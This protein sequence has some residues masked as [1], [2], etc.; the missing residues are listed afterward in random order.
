MAHEPFLI[1]GANG[2]T[3]RLIAERAKACGFRPI[4]A[5]RSRGPVEDI[6]SRVGFEARV[7]ELDSPDAVLE[8]IRGARLVLHCAGPFSKTSRPMVDGCLRAGAHYLDITGEVSVLEAVLSRDAEARAAKVVLLPAVGFDVVPTDCM[9]KTLHEELPDATRLELGFS[10]GMQPSPGTAKSTVEGLQMGAKVRENGAIVT[11]SRPRTRD[12]PFESGA[13]FGMSIP[14]GDLVTA[15]RSTKIPNITVYT[16]VPRNVARAAP[17]LKYV[18]PILRMPSV[19]R[20]LQRT[21]EKRA[22]GPTDEQRKTGRMW[23]WGRVENASGAAVE[24]HLDVSEGYEFTVVAA[25]ASVERVLGGE[26]PPGATT[27][28]LAFGADFVTTLPGASEFRLVHS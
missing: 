11:L 18:A 25:L 7:F 21:V 12:I 17:M 1:Y 2:F 6:A 10:S 19:V 13:R 20:F 28:S 16:V 9:A 22:K 5:G 4:V 3:G 14:W 8:G 26:V 27:P 24:A 15:H 23:V